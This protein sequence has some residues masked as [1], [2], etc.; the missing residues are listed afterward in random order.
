M[1]SPTPTTARVNMIVHDHKCIYLEA[2]IICKESKAFHYNVFVFRWFH[3]VLPLQNSGC[4]KL[5]VVPGEFHP[6]QTTAAYAKSIAF[7]NP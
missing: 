5:S 7:F 2:L 6:R 4:K 3:K 1:A